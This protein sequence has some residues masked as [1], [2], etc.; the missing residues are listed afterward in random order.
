MKI[1]CST[2][3]ASA[4]LL[5]SSFAGSVMAIQT[6]KRNLRL[7]SSSLN[8]NH[9]GL[10]LMVTDDASELIGFP[11]GLSAHEHDPSLMATT[12]SSRT[13]VGKS[14]N[15][16]HSRE[17]AAFLQ[18]TMVPSDLGL[19][20]QLTRFRTG[21]L[22]G[23]PYGAVGP[24]SS[25]AAV[26]SH[27]EARDKMTGNVVFPMTSLNGMF[28]ST[29]ID[30]P[31]SVLLSPT[32]LYDNFS[33]RFVLAAQDF[34]D[35]SKSYHMFLAIS[36]TNNPT[37]TTSDHWWFH[38]T[39]LFVPAS[40]DLNLGTP[41]F[42]SRIY[43]LGMDEEA[44]YLTTL[45]QSNTTNLYVAN[46]VWIY[47][48]A[49]YSNAHGMQ[50]NVWIYN[51]NNRT[52]G[53]MLGRQQPAVVRSTLNVPDGVGTY[54]IGYSGL[55]MYGTGSSALQLIRI[56]NPLQPGSITFT[57]TLLEVGII[58]DL[59][60]SSYSPALPDAPQSGTSSPLIDT[61][62]R[63][64]TG[65]AWH[66]GNLWIVATLLE[67]NGVNETAVV[68]W[69]VRANG[70]ANLSLA[71]SGVIGGEDISPNTFTFFPSL[72]VN[73]NTG[74][75]AVN[76]VA[77]SP[78]T[79]VGAYAVL[80][81]PSSTGNSTTVSV[82][83]PPQPTAIGTDVYNVNLGTGNLWGRSTSIAWDPMPVTNGTSAGNCFWAFNQYPSPNCVGNIGYPGVSGCWATT[84]ARLCA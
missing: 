78:T 1:H 69:Q 5:L 65:A 66:D 62:S 71:N 73:P 28:T 42:P 44:L 76:F 24:Y 60:G 55:R 58:D 36:K 50:T 80:L 43:G 38:K 20:N 72:D 40:A 25:I 54:I 8:N 12:P 6:N 10:A 63:S 27:I 48:K 39:D 82:S 56:D 67:P 45:M 22:P 74:D 17:L 37:N 4:A 33:Q 13:L 11:Q 32:I 75:V 18:T 15:D 64:V 47:D 26:S 7:S 14:K 81:S 19:S 51:F 29:F 34:D 2:I 41:S 53:L 23:D 35:M 49:A 57:R 79:Y 52:G 16:N 21:R 31:K 83:S 3:G 77:S 84:W 9:D 46:L 68:W 30:P 61:G 70:I 59:S